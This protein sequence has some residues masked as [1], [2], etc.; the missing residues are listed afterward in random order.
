[1]V[2]FPRNFRDGDGFAWTLNNYGNVVP[3]RRGEFSSGASNGL[4]IFE[5]DAKFSLGRRQLT[6]GP[7]DSGD[8]R[9]TRKVYVSDEDGFVRYLEILRNTGTSEV[10]RTVTISSNL[11]ASTA[12]LVR[13]SDGNRAFSAADSWLVRDDTRDPGAA[14]TFVTGDGRGQGPVSA[15]HG[16]FGSVSYSYE[17]DL[18]PGE[19]QIVMHFLALNRT[20]ARG[21]ADAKALAGLRGDA[22]HGLSKAELAAIVNFEPGRRN[23]NGTERADDLRGDVFD[24]TFR[25]RGGNDRVDGREGDDRISGDAGRDTI[26]G[27]NGDDRASGGSGR[28]TIDGGAGNDVL[29]GD[30]TDRTTS[31]R[32][33]TIPSPREKISISLTLPDAAN[34][35]SIDA[36]GFISRTPITSDRFNIA[37]VIDISGSTS[38]GFDGSVDV[39][40]MNGDGRAN[41]I[42]DA[43]IAGFEALLGGI[44]AQVGADNVDVALIT[45]QSS[46]T[47]DVLVNAAA[48]RDGDGLSDVVE[49][50]RALR[51]TGGT[52]FERGLEEARDYFSGAGAGQNLLFFLSDGENNSSSSTYT[53]DVAALRNANVAIRSFGAGENANEDH[54]DLVDDRRANNTEVI[55]LDPSDLANVLIDPGISRADVERVELFVN[56]RRVK[57]ID[58]ADLDSTP[59]GLSYSFDA[60]LTGLRPNAND[61]ITARLIASDAGRTTISTTQVVEVLR[62]GD[63]ADRILGGT[64]HDLVFGGGGNDDIRGDNGNDDLR[65]E[66]G[67]DVLRGGDGNDSLNGGFGADRMAGGTGNDVYV[68]GSR[69]DVIVERAGEGRDTVVSSFDYALGLTLENL[70]LEDGATRGTGN[71]LGNLIIGSGAADTL[72]GGG[73]N[74]EIRGG[75][76][77][78]LLRGGTG[79][80]LLIGGPGAD[81][82]LIDRL[83]GASADR[84]GD[85]TSGEDEFA[86]ENAVFTALGPAGALAASAFRAGSSA[87]DADDRIIYSSSGRLLYDADGDGAGDAILLAELEGSPILAAEDFVVV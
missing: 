71:R 83:P 25:A 8:V 52:D 9:E 15:E 60:R 33:T 43:E 34:G 24:E 76:G 53:D 17:L 84:V 26:F 30:G 86:L 22:L 41:T 35:R 14:V 56:G 48:D 49:A 51:S 55:V 64:G 65:G 31:A 47:T 40:D 46:A 72:D 54:L 10:T 77:N 87:S 28:D 67:A 78:D 69:R 5:S 42:L 44:T 82:F 63:A 61:T 21:I 18:E 81:R 3:G 68:A 20:G 79:A 62:E 58:G 11:Q 66:A 19:T 37:F 73:G 39:A 59:L 75:A 12:N 2:G 32:S 1:M 29:E 16:S 74:D 36:E 23:Y 38:S 80:D 57:V 50:L 45:F 4:F 13:T 70:R 27:R 7:D 6:F 85:F